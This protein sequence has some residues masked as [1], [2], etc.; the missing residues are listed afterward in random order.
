MAQIPQGQLK[1]SKW[2]KVLA[3]RNKMIEMRV[4]Q[5]LEEERI[6]RNE[7]KKRF[8]LKPEARQKVVDAIRDVILKNQEPNAH[9]KALLGYL[10]WVFDL[11][12]LLT[13][14]ERKQCKTRLKELTKDDFLWHSVWRRISKR[15]GATSGAAMLA[16]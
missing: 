7:K 10:R 5:K 15:V 8:L 16:P 1:A 4:W 9:T 3:D 13:K 2:I 6:V 11:R 12:K 14:S